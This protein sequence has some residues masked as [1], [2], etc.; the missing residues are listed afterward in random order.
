MSNI[1]IKD[2]DEHIFNIFRGTEFV[3]EWKKAAAAKVSTPS[4][5]YSP[6]LHN[7][8]LSKISGGEFA[9][10]LNARFL[11]SSTPQGHDWWNILYIKFVKRSRHSVAS[12]I[13]DLISKAPV[14]YEKL[15]GG[16]FSKDN[17]EIF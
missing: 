11:W 17:Y 10:I 1:L 9:G 4:Y 16:L 12:T 14:K 13:E 2:A 7:E 15:F 3:E 8:D 6:H 5:I